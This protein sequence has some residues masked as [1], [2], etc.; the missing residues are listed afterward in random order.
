M[1]QKYLPNR[2][3]IPEACEWMKEQTGEPWTLAH[4]LEYGLMPWFW[5][6]HQPGWPDALFG[7]RA[8]GYLAPL[9]FAGDTQRLAADGRDVLVTM[10]RTH[11]GA[12]M[13]VGPPAWHFPIDAL[14]FLRDDITR[15]AGA[16]SKPAAPAE[17]ATDNRPKWKIPGRLEHEAREIGEQWMNTQSKKP[18][19]DAIAKHVEGELKNRDRRGPRRDYWDWQTIKREALTGITGRK[20]SGKK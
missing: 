9:C 8:E 15:L 3:S 16:L 5:L 4:L 17:S 6:E 1:T 7:G 14:R 2:A 13:K 19:V 18:G 20:A 10:T 12:L 11:D